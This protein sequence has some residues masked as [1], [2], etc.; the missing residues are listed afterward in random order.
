MSFDEE[1]DA[2]LHGECQAEIARLDRIATELQV[3]CDKQSKRIAYLLDR[4]KLIIGEPINAEF[5][6]EQALNEFLGE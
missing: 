3:T 1:P 5:I 2:P 6:A 4:M